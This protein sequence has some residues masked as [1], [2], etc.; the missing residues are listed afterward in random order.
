MIDEV[1]YVKNKILPSEIRKI[2]RS[3]E[4]L[5]VVFSVMYRDEKMTLSN[6]VKTEIAN[7]K[8]LTFINVPHNAYALGVKKIMDIFGSLIG[9]DNSLSAADC[10]LYHDQTQLPGTG[11]L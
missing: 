4:E 10:S 2:V 11:N 3:C 1:L 7:R 9:R 8:F 5:G 6:A